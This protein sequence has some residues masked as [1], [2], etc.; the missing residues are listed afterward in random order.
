VDSKGQVTRNHRTPTI[1]FRHNGSANVA[2]ADS[3]ATGR[4]DMHSVTTNVYD[5]NPKAM[6]IG[7]FGPEVGLAQMV[8]TTAAH[9]GQGFELNGWG[10]VTNCW[11]VSLVPSIGNLDVLTRW[12]RRIRERWPGAEC[13][14]LGDFGSA[15]RAARRYNDGLAYRFVQRGTGI[16]GSDRNLEIRWFMTRE[17][18]LALLRDWKANGP[19][20]VID[21]TRYDLPALEPADMTRRWSLLGRINQ[22]G[23][24]PQDA[25]IPFEA[26]AGEERELIGRRFPELRAGTGAAKELP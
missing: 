9:F 3:H 1:H 13:L 16:G 17:F 15:F 12:A 19:E 2:W 6:G 8:E 21:F 26:L 5:A 7:W 25:P 11:E 14:T 4:D 24:R 22:K 20:R 23:T 18:R 10:W